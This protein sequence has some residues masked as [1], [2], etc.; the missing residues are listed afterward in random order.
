MGL[1][2]DR[3]EAGQ[4]LQSK[5]KADQ[6]IKSGAREIP[7]HELKFQPFLVCVVDNGP[8]DAAGFAY[9]A[10]EYM[11]FKED[12]SPRPRRWLVCPLAIESQYGK[13]TIAEMMR[14]VQTFPEPEKHFKRVKSNTEEHLRKIFPDIVVLRQ[15]EQKE[16]DYE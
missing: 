11:V 8:F 1:Y 2:L 9:T 16:D 10:Q 7:R 3:D 13:D 5:G 6:L 14:E 4:P 12:R 15:E